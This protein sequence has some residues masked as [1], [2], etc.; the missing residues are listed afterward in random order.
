M[1]LLKLMLDPQGI[2][3]E[4]RTA[5]LKSK[6]PSTAS[7]TIKNLQTASNNNRKGKI[8]INSEKYFIPFHAVIP[9]SI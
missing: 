4:N 1:G 3:W 5:V 9:N 8:K 6:T 7:F 2:S